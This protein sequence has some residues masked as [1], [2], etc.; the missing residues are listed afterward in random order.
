[1]MSFDLELTIRIVRTDSVKP[2]FD[3]LLCC[4]PGVT[5]ST[6]TFAPT[7]FSSAA[8]LNYSGCKLRLAHDVRLRWCFISREWIEAR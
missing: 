3:L 8:P 5:S 2:S 1:M 7:F 4:R 6:F